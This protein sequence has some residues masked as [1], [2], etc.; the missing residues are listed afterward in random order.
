MHDPGVRVE[1]ST[2]PFDVLPELEMPTLL[3]DQDP[4]VKK[5]MDLIKVHK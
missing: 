5:S 4:E 3:T 2:L 1:S